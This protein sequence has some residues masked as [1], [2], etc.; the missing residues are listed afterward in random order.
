[1]GE[2]NDPIA[3]LLPDYLGIASEFIDLALA[4][5]GP[6]SDDRPGRVLAF[7]RRGPALPD[8]AAW[9]EASRGWTCQAGVELRETERTFGDIGATLH[10]ERARLLVL[11]WGFWTGQGHAELRPETEWFARELPCDL[12]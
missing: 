11:E 1:M 12:A 10:E 6:A 9:R 8:D 2:A 4:I 5:T 3:V 7:S